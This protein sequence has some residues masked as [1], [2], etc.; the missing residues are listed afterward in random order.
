MAH[1]F[2]CCSSA[3]CR[4]SIALSSPALTGCGLYC[5]TLFHGASGVRWRADTGK[6][7]SPFFLHTLISIRFAYFSW[8]WLSRRLSSSGRF[9]RT[10][11]RLRR[12]A[13]VDG[14]IVCVIALFQY[15]TAV[16]IVSTDIDTSSMW[17]YTPLATI[18]TRIRCGFVLHARE[19]CERRCA[20]LFHGSSSAFA[21]DTEVV[22]PTRCSAQ[23]CLY[24][25]CPISQE[26]RTSGLWTGHVAR[27][28]KRGKSEG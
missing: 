7:T 17:K 16:E 23:Q 24:G 11:A 1:V 5:A 9:T 2:G 25:V 21:V 6:Y 19:G 26:F 18:L 3:L 12:T 10:A 13:L 4:F 28:G 27:P 8:K 22:S 20:T 14:L 15:P